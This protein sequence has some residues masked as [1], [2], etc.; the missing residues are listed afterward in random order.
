[1]NKKTN[2]SSKL[3]KINNTTKALIQDFFTSGLD[4]LVFFIVSICIILYFFSFNVSV[5]LIP[6]SIL[7]II[8]R[9]STAISTAISADAVVTIVIL[10]LIILSVSASIIN[11]KTERTLVYERVTVYKD[12][13]F[14]KEGFLMIVNNSD[15]EN[16]RIA[17]L[18]ELTWYKLQQMD[19]QPIKTERLE[20]SYRGVKHTNIIFSC[21]TN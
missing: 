15:K 6:I 1:M 16:T 20:T 4:V 5:I 9:A 11:D 13:K 21:Q 19:C 3:S 18:N 10:Y 14:V 2:S 8:F 17:N 7:Y 12:I